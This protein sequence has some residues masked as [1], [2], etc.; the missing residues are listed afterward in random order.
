MK[1][2]LREQIAEIVASKLRSN[3]GHNPETSMDALFC[4]DQILSLM[5]EV[6]EL[7]RVIEDTCSERCDKCTIDECTIFDIKAAAER[8]K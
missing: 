3:C 1:D 6:D 7:L 5:P 8:C 2:K 4:A